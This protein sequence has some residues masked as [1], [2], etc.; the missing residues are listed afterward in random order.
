MAIDVPSFAR[1]SINTFHFDHLYCN[2]RAS[3]LAIAEFFHTCELTKKFSIRKKVTDD[4]LLSVLK[5][6]WPSL[7]H[8]TT[9]SM[10][11][12]AGS[13]AL[14]ADCDARVSGVQLPQLATCL[15]RGAH[16]V[17]GAHRK[18]LHTL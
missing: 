9:H 18:F 16:A 11:C 17:C 7:M 1:E 13:A 14:V 15:Q 3:V 6:M 5:T 4:I 10:Q 12:V 2:D 8:E